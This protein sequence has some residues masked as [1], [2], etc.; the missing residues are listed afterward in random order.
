[1]INIGWG[2]VGWGSTII[3]RAAGYE[4][5]SDLI[6]DKA[7]FDNH[8]LIEPRKG[9]IRA[10]YSIDKN[11]LNYINNKTVD[12]LPWGV[13]V[14]WAYGLNWSP[15][16]IYNGPNAFSQFLDDIN[17]RKFL[18]NNSP[19]LVLYGYKYL[20]SWRPIGRYILCQEPETFRTILLNYKFNNVSGEFVI[21]NRS[22]QSAAELPFKNL[23]NATTNFGKKINI[24][25]FDGFVFGYLDIKSSLYGKILSV[26][27]KPSLVYVEFILNNSTNNESHKYILNPNNA[28][29]GILVSKYVGNMKDLVL[30]FKNEQNNDVESI[31]I[32]ADDPRQFS[33]E[34]GIEFMGVRMNKYT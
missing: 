28:R 26:I 6:K 32:S 12:I 19:Q 25:N 30:I 33:D 8:N 13:D 18:G 17:S 20:D 34:F 16:P 29:N 2:A 4:L 7:H 9:R 21:L 31:I 15:R 11:T 10:H 24:P 27:Y 1:L 22:E 14:I 23:G 5:A 3:D